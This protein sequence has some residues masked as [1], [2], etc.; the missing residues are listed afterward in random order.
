MHQDIVNKGIALKDIGSLKL[1]DVAIIAGQKGKY[2]I[3]F[4][5][6]FMAM[7]DSYSE[8]H[9]E[10]T[11]EVFLSTGTQPTKPRW[12]RSIEQAFQLLED[13]NLLKKFTVELSRA[14][15]S[16]PPKTSLNG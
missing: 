11:E 6:S 10:F 15:F 16:E 3:I 7:N 5:L 12:F 9:E 1:H 8:L 13:A 2:C 14:V 4:S